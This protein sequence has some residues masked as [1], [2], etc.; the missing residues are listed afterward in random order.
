MP[1]TSAAVKLLLLLSLHAVVHSQGRHVCRPYAL[2]DLQ[3]G[4]K[5]RGH[6]LMTITVKS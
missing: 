1:V 5:K 4:P 6:K 2:L 3:G